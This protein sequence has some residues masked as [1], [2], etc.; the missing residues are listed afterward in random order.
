MHSSKEVDSS[1]PPSESASDAE[2]SQTRQEH[3]RDGPGHHQ[4]VS[5]DDSL[6]IAYQGSA[7]SSSTG[8]AEQE[9]NVDSS[10]NHLLVR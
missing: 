1:P 10:M 3:A 6:V 5:R 9:K 4:H 7:D 8:A 2:P